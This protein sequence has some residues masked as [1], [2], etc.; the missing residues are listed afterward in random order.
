MLTSEFL[1]NDKYFANIL[2][3]DEVAY[4]FRIPIDTELDPSINVHLQYGT[5]IIFKQW[6]SGLYYFDTTNEEF[7]QD[8]TADYTFL[9][10]VECNTSW[11]HGLE[12]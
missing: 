2:Y 8:Q 3:F 5:R 10:T 1:F 11:F 6:L 7:I 12:I 4:K 9:N